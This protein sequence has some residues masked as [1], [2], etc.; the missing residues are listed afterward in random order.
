MFPDSVRNGTWKLFSFS[1]AGL[2]KT[3]TFSRSSLWIVGTSFVVLGLPVLFEVE[4]VQTEE[5]ALMQ[6]RQVRENR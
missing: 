3:Y 2:K 4:R 5:A 6:Q 1:M